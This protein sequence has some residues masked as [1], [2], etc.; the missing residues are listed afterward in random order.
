[1]S[2]VNPNYRPRSIFGPLLL[3]GIGVVWLLYNMGIISRM[4]WWWWFSRYWPVLLIVWGVSRLVEQVWARHKGYATP[5][6]GGG[7]VF[8]LILLII[9]GMGASA[10]RNV[11]WS[12]LSDEVDFNNDD[13]FNWFGSHYEFTNDFAQTIE[14]GKPVKIIVARGTLNVTP[15][16]DDQTHVIVHKTLSGDSESEAKSRNDETNPK[17]EQRG[18]TWLLDLTGDKFTHGRFNLDVQ[19]PK[20]FP[21]SLVTNRG[22]IHVSDR[23]GNIDLEANR[24]N[25]FAENIKG[26]A[27]LQL[28]RGNVTVKN[29]DGDVT[30]NGSVFRTEISDVTGLLSLNGSYWNG[31]ELARI[32]K[33]VSFKTDRTDMQFAKLEGDLSMDPGSLRA[34]SLAGPFRLRTSSKNVELEKLDGDVQIEDRNAPVELHLKAPLGKVEVDNHRGQII[35]DV[36]ADSGFQVDAESSYGNIQSD[37]DLDINNS[38]R[39]ATARG[40]IGKGG[41]QIRLRT[42]R[43]T[44]QIRKD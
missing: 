27:N 32:G 16:S 7:G 11:N 34:T 13:F 17:F 26:N 9:V 44:I 14:P 37:F 4:G 1:M 39:D 43:G 31:T 2:N 35:V 15:S 42:E 12:G 25:I 5:R 24:G 23:G 40:T 22:D 3:V 28:Q 30:V 10:S 33:Q 29:V 18:D 41:P 38:R 19:V 20:N 21:V 8:L 36:P 6:I